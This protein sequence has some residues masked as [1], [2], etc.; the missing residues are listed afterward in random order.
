VPL[1]VVIQG[2]DEPLTDPRIVAAAM[3][4]MRFRKVTSNGIGLTAIERRGGSLSELLGLH[5]AA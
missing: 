3:E 1:R 2:V 5:A 4:A